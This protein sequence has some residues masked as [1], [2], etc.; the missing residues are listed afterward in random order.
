MST[1]D[2]RYRQVCSRFRTR[3]P[4]DDLD[5]VHQAYVETGGGDYF[6]AR[7]FLRRKDQQRRLSWRRAREKPL[8]QGIKGY[9]QEPC[10]V[11]LLNE[12]SKVVQEA[13]SRLPEIYQ[14]VVTLRFFEG[15]SPAEIATTLSVPRKTVYTRLRQANELLKALLV[16]YFVDGDVKGVLAA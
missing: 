7:A 10:D 16:N 12:R 15:L 13:V 11:V 4:S 14:T 3:F 9:S 1:F 8:A 6:E 2:E 5:A